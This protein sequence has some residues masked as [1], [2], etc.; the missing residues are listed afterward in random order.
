MKKSVLICIIIGAVV[1][2][3][4]AGY[5][6]GMTI[7][8]SPIN[9][10][11]TTASTTSS[12][13]TTLP[14]TPNDGGGTTTTTT[15]T[16]TTSNNQGSQNPS[17]DPSGYTKLNTPTI[18][19]VEYDTVIWE[20]VPN[21][22]KYKIYING[23]YSYTTDADN[24]KGALKYAVNEA[25]QYLTEAQEIL[26]KVQAIGNGREYR[27]S[28]RSAGYTYYYV[29]EKQAL[30]EDEKKL[31]NYGIGYG[32]NLIEYEAIDAEMISDTRIVDIYKLLTLGEY[33]NPSI[34]EGLFTSYNFSSIDELMS[35]VDGSINVGGSLNYAKIGSVKAQYNLD[36]G[37]DRTK[38]TYNETYVIQDGIV[39]KAYEVKNYSLEELKHCLTQAF[40]EDIKKSS[41]M[42]E[43]AWFKYMYNKYG[44]HVIL[45]VVTGGTYTAQYMIS[46]NSESVSQ[47]VTE[48]FSANGQV[49][50][51]KLF[52]LG[53]ELGVSMGEDMSW[54]GE[55]TEAHFNIHWT[56]SNAG[57]TPTLSGLNDAIR[58]F[59]NGINE[60]NA[61]AVR[62]TK[63]GAISIGSLISLIDV[64]LGQK[65]ENYLN[66][67]GSE[68]YQKLYSKY[69]KAP[70]I[71]TT[72]ENN[73]L[74]IDLSGY[75][76]VGSLE[77]IYD[78][79]FVDGVLT[80]YPQMM[81]QS[82][83]KI[84]I[85]GDFDSN[86]TLINSFSVDLA[87]TWDKDITIEVQNLGVMCASS[88]GIVKK[89]NTKVNIEYIGTNA[90]QKLNGGIELYSTVN[91]KSYKFV[92]DSNA[93][94]TLDFST[95]DFS[96]SARLPISYKNRGY[97]FSG[98]CDEDGVAITDRD[99]YVLDS[100]TLSSQPIYV[101]PEY[102][103]VFSEGLEYIL[104]EDGQSYSVFGLGSCRDVYLIIPSTYNGLPVTGIVEGAFRGSSGNSI[105]GVF[106]KSVTIPESIT[107]IGEDAFWACYSL[108]EV[109]NKSSLDIQAGTRYYGCIGAYVRDII[110]DESQSHLKEYG[111]YLFY[112]DGTE[113]ILVAYLGTD[114]R[115]TLPEYQGG[116]EYSV[117]ECIL[118]N[119]PD[120]TTTS[121]TIPSYI[122]DLNSLAFISNTLV[123]IYNK[124]SLEIITS[125]SAEENNNRDAIRVDVKHI[126]SH[127]SESYIKT[128]GDYLFYD[129]G[130]SIHLLRYTGNDKEITL[131]KYRGGK[132]YSIYNGAFAYCDFTSITIPDFVTEI[133]FCIFAYC[134]SLTNVVLPEHLTDINELGELGLF[135]FCAS[136][137]ITIP[138][139]ITEIGDAMF[140]RCS[141]LTSVTIPDSVTSIG[142]AAFGA[143]TSLTSVTIPDS[144]TSIGYAAFVACT[145]LTNVTI[146]NSV[147]YIGEAAFGLCNSLASVNYDGTV[148]E[149]Y[150]LSDGLDLFCLT[151]SNYTIY[152]SDGEIAK[153][154]TVTYY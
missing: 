82:I 44:T 30:S 151:T 5:L 154:G 117:G 32:Y 129:D 148:E 3:I 96:D 60:S 118:V 109:C 59:E 33:Y 146:P 99:G 42:T 104:N 121:V 52:S 47:S 138:D 64:S 145:S 106:F 19:K 72:I 76:A 153:D 134:P 81:G 55:T 103:E 27:D 39:T 131:P 143:C 125:E 1:L 16:T 53:L 80:I 21:A 24:T 140:M 139:S 87:G 100:Y 127:E 4:G 31:Y 94:E 91:N 69:A 113:I 120:Y 119:N 13:T 46:T 88:N 122:T 86:R 98:W 114:S 23:D 36:L 37:I 29:P 150:A 11:T 147:T 26:V 93:N 152:C 73:V 63:N 128:V 71:P 75:Q 62:F 115:I 66:V 135:A 57:G 25:G 18:L 149:W 137:N 136:T 101:Y 105:G 68:E 49:S 14:T 7:A 79:N 123:E 90:I 20:A 107:S 95:L 17:E 54:K 130:E 48:K 74:T 70:A 35:H 102:V 67:K 40:V 2:A 92:F 34:A 132:E 56:G 116:K 144:V 45:G 133:G 65:Y 9:S 78:A 126:I 43:S 84:I 111:D 110:T 83:D 50:L 6:V 141:S 15:T 124:S 61:V 12:S 77:N 58:R 142:Y 51:S 108:I 22:V 41:E 97:E 89:S 85:K 38:Y 8:K 28:D 10:T 112:D